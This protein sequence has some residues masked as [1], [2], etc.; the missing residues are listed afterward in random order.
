MG[1]LAPPGM[2]IIGEVNTRSAVAPS[3]GQVAGSVARLNGLE[4]SNSRPQVG[5][6]KS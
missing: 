5:Q 4:T 3:W 1:S 6:R 2:N